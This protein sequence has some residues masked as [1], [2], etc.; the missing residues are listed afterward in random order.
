MRKGS[1]LSG[2]VGVLDGRSNRAAST[3]MHAFLYGPLPDCETVGYGWPWFSCAARGTG[4]W[5]HEVGVLVHEFVEIGPSHRKLIRP[6]FSPG[7]P[8]DAPAADSDCSQQGRAVTDL[9]FDIDVA[10]L[11]G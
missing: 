2:V 4:A 6:S 9:K 1:G 5:R 3:D 8:C 11:D 10:D 7:P